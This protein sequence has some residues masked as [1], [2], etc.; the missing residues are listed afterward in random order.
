MTMEDSPHPCREMPTR[1]CPRLRDAG[2]PGEPCARFE[3]ED[4]EPWA[5]DLL[6]W[7]REMRND[8]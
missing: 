8:R 5:L 6:V 7:G 1:S 2:C 4:P 3:S